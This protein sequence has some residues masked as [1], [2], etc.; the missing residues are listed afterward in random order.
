MVWFAGPLE[1]GA[2]VDKREDEGRALR[3]AVV[4]RDLTRV[5]DF[6]QRPVILPRA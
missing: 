6:R 1:A 4:G 3:A 5:L 2:F